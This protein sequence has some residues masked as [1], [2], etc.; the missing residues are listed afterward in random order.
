MTDLTTDFLLAIFESEDI[1][2]Y[3]VKLEDFG[4]TTKLLVINARSTDSKEFFTLKSTVFTLP[5]EI[6]KA[7]DHWKQNKGAS[8]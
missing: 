6:Q 7:V 8:L 3:T 5:E 4:S 2:I 1:V